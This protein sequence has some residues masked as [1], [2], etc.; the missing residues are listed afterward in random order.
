MNLVIYELF[1][2]Q[3]LT[4][5]LV[6]LGLE[7]EVVVIINSYDSSKRQTNT[8]SKDDEVSDDKAATVLM[9]ASVRHLQCNMN[10]FS[11][12]P[13]TLRLVCCLKS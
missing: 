7:R 13:I 9:D 10:G 11:G 12:I 4:I 2:N 8:D 3:E 1:K 5:K 6:G